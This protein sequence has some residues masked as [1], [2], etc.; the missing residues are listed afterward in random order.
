MTRERNLATVAAMYHAFGVG[1]IP[2]VLD[3]LD[4]TVEWSNRG[5]EDIPYFGVK[6]GHEGALAVFGFLGENVD[7]TVFEPHTMIA[8]EDRVVTLVRVAATVRSTQVSYDEETVH[9]FDFNSDGK[10]VRFRDYQDTDAVA[11]ALRGPI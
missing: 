8:D 2:A 3:H 11:A 10:V 7:I 4:Q 9:V 5:P 1:D 6:H